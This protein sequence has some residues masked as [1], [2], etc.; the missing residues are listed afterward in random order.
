MQ[1]S[2]RSVPV[3]VL[4]VLAQYDVEL[5]WS[6]DQEVVEAF[7]SQCPDEAF[8]DRVR[9]G[10]SDRG[11]DDPQV[12][13]GEDGVERGGELAVP[14]ADKESEPVRSLRGPSAGCGPAG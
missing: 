8:H 4:D 7:P 5:A 14:V 9:P 2:V 3:V 6:G 13:A 10:R 1:R 11:A 12:G